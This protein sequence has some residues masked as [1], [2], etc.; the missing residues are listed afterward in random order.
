M[1]PATREGRITRP[2]PEEGRMSDIIDKL[3]SDDQTLADLGSAIAG[4]ATPAA[5]S[6]V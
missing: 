2:F 5:P 3:S 1:L 4:E 6:D